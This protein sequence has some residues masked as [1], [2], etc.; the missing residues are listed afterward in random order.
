MLASARTIAADETHT[1]GSREKSDISCII[2]DV[3]IHPA[4]ADLGITLA[5]ET[6]SY[7]DIA[8]CLEA[9]RP[10]VSPVTIKAAVA[11]LSIVLRSCNHCIQKR[12]SLYLGPT[13]DLEGENPGT[14]SPS[15][16]PTVSELPRRIATICDSLSCQLSAAHEEIA[17][18]NGSDVDC[19]REIGDSVI[20]RSRGGAPPPMSNL[21]VGV[22]V[23]AAED[24][25]RSAVDHRNVAREFCT[26]VTPSSM[27][28]LAKLEAA[29]DE[30]NVDL[31]AKY[32]RR[33]TKNTQFILITHRRGTMEEADVL[34]GVTMQEDG[35]SKLLE[36][37]TTEMAKKLGIA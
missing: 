16:S 35:I 24:T 4:V 13:G 17:A 10:A 18:V 29:L 12:T 6:G 11:D 32:V 30:N 27:T 14:V 37:K 28:D 36:L 5:T 3:I 33:M 19:S 23:A 22:A 1:A 15:R 34:Y 20:E 31:F 9:D 7:F 8:R 26:R 25:H 2:P 21:G